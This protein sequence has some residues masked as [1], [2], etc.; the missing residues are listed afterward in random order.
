M[1]GGA[2]DDR[3]SGGSEND[4]IDGGAGDDSMTG[5][6]GTDEFRFLD[7]D[8]GHDTITDWQIGE[9]FRIRVFD[10]ATN[11]MEV[12]ELAD[13]TITGDGTDTVVMVQNDN[14]AN[15]IEVHAA[16]GVIDINDF[17]IV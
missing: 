5:G 16:T 10:E 1:I 2:G 3:V 13:F 14:P 8:F 17:L 7:R 15:I 11:R 6:T 12:A 9:R 4:Q